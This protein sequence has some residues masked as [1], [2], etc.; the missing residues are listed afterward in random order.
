[1]HVPPHDLAVSLVSETL[2]SGWSFDTSG[3]TYLAV[4]FGSHHWRVETSQGERLFVTVDDL[5]ADGT[6]GQD[7]VFRGLAQALND[8]DS[9]VAWN[10]LVGTLQVLVS[11]S[12]IRWQ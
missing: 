7:R 2:A 11:G 3:I 8:V 1:M 5:G 6:E 9:R 12:L 4:G 10:G